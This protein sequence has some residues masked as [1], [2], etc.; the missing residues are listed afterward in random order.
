MELVELSCG[1]GGGQKVRQHQMRGIA[2]DRGA[3][4][5]LWHRFRSP[6]FDVGVLE[7]IDVPVGGPVEH[8]GGEAGFLKQV[9]DRSALGPEG[10]RC[11]N[12]VF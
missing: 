8:I 1:S 2:G 4:V 11:L 5:S 9:D 6:D 12:P 10:K 7:M 3:G